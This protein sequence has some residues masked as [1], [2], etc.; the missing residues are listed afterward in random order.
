MLGKLIRHEWKSTYK[1]CGLLLLMVAGVTLLGVLGFALPL[2]M[3]PEMSLHYGFGT[4]MTKVLGSIVMMMSLIVYIVMLIGVTYGM[5]IWLGIHFYRTM[6]SDEGYLTQTLP[7]SARDLIVSKTLVAGIWEMLTAL[8][9]MA[10]VFI[11]ILAYLDISFID[12]RQLWGEMFVGLDKVLT[13]IEWVH[14]LGS[15]IIMLLLS[16][17]GAVLTLFGSLTI[18]QLSR[19]YKALMG[20]LAYFGVIFAQMVLNYIFQFIAAFGLLFGSEFRA[21]VTDSG[22]PLFMTYDGS[23]LVMLLMGV[24]MYFIM[25]YVL[26]KKLDMD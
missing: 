17:F 9:V 3:I 16:P 21:Y 24:G 1:M 25:H 20:I 10:S 8:G 12:I 23:I 2:R 19:K 15:V 11:L 6:Y 13:D 22:K 7:V 5:M 14:M 18:G 26:T 4:S